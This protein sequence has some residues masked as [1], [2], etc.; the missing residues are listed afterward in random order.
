MKLFFIILV[1]SFFATFSKAQSGT[2]E[3]KV[4]LMGQR[5]VSPARMH[6]TPFLFSD[7]VKGSVVLTD[8]E[9]SEEIPLQ[10]DALHDEL[11]TYDKNSFSTIKIEKA[12]LQSFRVTFFGEDWFFEQRRFDALV[13]ENRFFRVLF[14]GEIELLCYYKA[15]I[16][17]VSP[18]KDTDN[19]MKNQEYAASQH[20]FLYSRASGYSPVRLKRKSL[21]R[22]VVKENQAL[23]RQVLRQNHIEITGYQSFARALELFDANHVKLKF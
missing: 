23:A 6:G 4:K 20:Y 8:G 18:Y 13:P 12:T 11:L 19:I 5:A 21:L 3:G 2:N 9:N 1:F 14:K 7:W 10:Y 17:V 16:T 22:R 15:D